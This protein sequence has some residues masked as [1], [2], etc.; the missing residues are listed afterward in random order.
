MLIVAVLAV[1]G[2]GAFAAVRLRAP[3]LDP[4]SLCLTDAPAPESVIILADA[5]DAMLARHKKRLRAAAENEV[6]RLPRHARLSVLTLD[7]A[8]PREPRLLFSKCD[9]GRGRD[10]NPLFANPKS[11]DA[12]REAEFL[13]PLRLAL[14]KT[15]AARAAS[16]SPLIDGVWAAMTD[17]ELNTP[18]GA[19][20]LILVSDLLQHEADGLSLYVPGAR[21]ETYRQSAASAALTPDLSG[22]AVRVIVLDRAPHEAL[23]QAAQDNFWAPYF[24]EAGADSVTFVD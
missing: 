4:T 15:G 7:A 17:P 3:T 19:R 13:A 10:I 9:P 1:L 24:E 12:R 14:T 23:Q 20:S 11:A 5:T 16:A 2:A 18:S 21:F 8:A 6:A 22:V